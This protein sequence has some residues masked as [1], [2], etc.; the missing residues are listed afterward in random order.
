MEG[1]VDHHA[2]PLP[3]RHRRRGRARQAHRP[4]PLD[5]HR[6]PALLGARALLRRGEAAR[7]RARRDR[8]A[9]ARTPRRPSRRRQRKRCAMNSRDRRQPCSRRSPPA[10]VAYVFVYPLLSGERA[11]REAA[12]GARRAADPSAASARSG[13]TVEPPRAGRAEPEGARG[14]GRRRAQGHARGADRAGGADLDE[15]DVL[16]SSAP[17]PAPR[18]RPSRCS[19]CRASPI[20]AA[21]AAFVGGA[22]P[23]A[24]VPQLP[25]QA[26]HRASFIKELPERHRRDRARHP[27]GLPLGD[28][29]R[30]DRRARRQEPVRGEFRD[31]RRG[32]DARHVDRRGGRRS[33]T[34]ACRSPEANFFAH[35]HQHPAEVRRQSL[36]G[37]RQPVEGAARAQKM[38]G[39]IKAMSMEAKASAGSSAPAVHRRRAR[40]TSRARIHRAA[41]DDADRQDRARRRRRLDVDRRL[42][43][44]EDDQ[45]RLLRDAPTRVRIDAISIRQTQRPAVHGHDPGRRSPRR[46][47]SLTVAMPLVEGDSLGKRMKAVAIERDTH[48]R[49]ASASGSRS[50]SRRSSLR[51]SPKAYMKQIVDRSTSTTGSAPRTRE[52]QLRWPATAASTPRSRSCSSGW[53]MPIDAPDLAGFY[54]FVAQDL[55]Q[56]LLFKLGD[57]AS[58]RPI[59][60]V[61]APELYPVE[62]DHEAAGSRSAA[63]GPTRSTCC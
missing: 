27:A 15:A 22:R 31:D 50:A 58:A 49:R 10:G 39:K 44:E 53:S 23:A 20:V 5:R 34:S 51:Q 57:R 43:D 8:N 42:R 61:K 30:I 62:P 56:P 47:R 63:P 59:V 18:A 54:L 14:A 38:R 19:S 36:G 16:S 2:G 29:L 17:S 45:L 25:A 7:R 1:D 48:P 4:P 55:D 46:P 12:E 9:S 3:L 41:V 24:L 35:R 52:A 11:R 32:A 33:C 40:S 28:C 6:P 21:G 13:R 37:A 60:G 26:P